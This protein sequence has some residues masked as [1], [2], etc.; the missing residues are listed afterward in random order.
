VPQNILF[1]FT[2]FHDP[3]K[4][5][6]VAGE[7]QSGPILTALSGLKIDRV[8]LFTTPRTVE[9]TRATSKSLI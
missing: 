7:E 1:T 9:M 2:S 8:L 6:P 5:T 4:R 3:Y